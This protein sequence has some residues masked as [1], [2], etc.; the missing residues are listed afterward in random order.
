MMIQAAHG[1][2]NFHPCHPPSIKPAIH[3]LKAEGTRPKNAEGQIPFSPTNG[4]GDSSQG[5]C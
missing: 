5:S 4:G 2:E 3:P 1:P